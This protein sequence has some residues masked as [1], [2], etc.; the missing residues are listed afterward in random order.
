MDCTKLRSL[1]PRPWKRMRAF[2]GYSANGT[3]PRNPVPKFSTI[4]KLLKRPEWKDSQVEYGSGTFDA[5]YFCPSCNHWH[6]ET[7]TAPY[8]VIRGHA[9]SHARQMRIRIDTAEDR[10]KARSARCL[11]DQAAAKRRAKDREDEANRRLEAERKQAA[12]EAAVKRDAGAR[13]ALPPMPPEPVIA[14]RVAGE[15]SQVPSPSERIA[16][17]PS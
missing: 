4:E 10:N 12:A 17:G 14:E 11:A 6:T 1:T 2:T 15:I 7:E 9:G 8:A 5:S 3:H 16:R 13:A